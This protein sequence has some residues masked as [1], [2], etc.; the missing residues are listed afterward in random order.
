MSGYL[1]TLLFLVLVSVLFMNTAIAGNIRDHTRP[2]YESDTPVS[3]TQ[4][5]E[6]TLT[7]VKFD[8]QNLQTWVRVAAQIDKTGE[9]LTAQSCLSNTRL[10]QLGQRIRAFT[11]N[12]KSSI[13]AARVSQLDWKN[14][15]LTINAHLSRKIQQES[16]NF[17]MEILVE[18]GYRM[19]IPKEA[20]IEED[21]QQIVYVQK[22]PGHYLPQQIRTGIKGE[23]Y[24]EVTQGLIEGDQV[25]TLGSFFIDAE[26]KLKSTQHSGAGHAHKHH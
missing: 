20:I 9:Y 17:I 1:R 2:N 16:P 3:E 26:F 12:S 22:H 5:N 24:T 7:L 13:Y 19:S 6:L 4:A 21:G 8:Q 15:C 25:V 23:L 11:A 10:L 14:K 18:H